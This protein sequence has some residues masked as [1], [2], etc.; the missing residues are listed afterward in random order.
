[1]N[2]RTRR[3]ALIRKTSEMRSLLLP[4]CLL[5]SACSAQQGYY[6]G[7]AWQRQ[8]CDK[9]LNKTDYDTCMQHTSGSYDDYRRQTRQ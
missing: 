5:L 9:Y 1:M 6:A 2:K 4:I 3:A 7:Q 8:E